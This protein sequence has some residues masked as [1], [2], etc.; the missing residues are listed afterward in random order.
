MTGKDVIAAM[1]KLNLING[2]DFDDGSNNATNIDNQ[3]KKSASV[4][5]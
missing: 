4:E 3:P 2:I 1:S 5:Y